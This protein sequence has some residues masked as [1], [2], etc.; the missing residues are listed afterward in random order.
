MDFLAARGIPWRSVQPATFARG[1]GTPAQGRNSRLPA[2]FLFP[3]SFEGDFPSR[4]P[5]MI[6]PCL[7]PRFSNEYQQVHAM[8]LSNVDLLKLAEAS[9]EALLP[10]CGRKA[11][12]DREISL[13][14]VGARLGINAGHESSCLGHA[15]T[16][17]ARSPGPG[18]P[19]CT[20]FPG[21]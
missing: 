10:P 16:H 11:R 17:G 21:I 20:V 6:R 4:C 18:D 1:P 9:F 5:A 8:G 2:A 12:D 7:K 13:R 19:A 3:P 14:R 15:K